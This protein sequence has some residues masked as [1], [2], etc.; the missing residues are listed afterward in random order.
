M[1]VAAG[2]DGRTAASSW[3]PVT[4]ALEPA[5]PVAATLTVGVGGN[6][7]PV[8]ETVRVEVAAGSRKV[9][10]FVVPNGDVRVTI[11]ESDAEPLTVRPPNAGS[12]A[13]FLVGLLGA[14]A[15]GLPPLRS[16]LIG[17]SG[18]WVFV[19][20]A[21]LEQ[22]SFALEPL[23]TLVADV[24]ALQE[25]TPRGRA[26]LAAGVAAG[27]DLVIVG[28]VV[29]PKALGLPWTVPDDA[30]RLDGADLGGADVPVGTVAWAFPAGY[31]RI[32]TTPVRPG[33][34][35]LGR[36]GELWSQL[37]QPNPRHGDDQTDYR[38][39]Q[40]PHQFTRLLA[41][42]GGN[43]PALPWLG[44]FVAA[45]VIVVGPV[46]GVLLSRMRR[47]ELAWAT[48]PMVTVIFTL[49]AFLGATSGRPPTGAAARLAFWNDGA[50]AEIVAAGVRAATPGT[51]VLQ[52]D[53]ADWTARPL[54][55]NG[56]QGIVSRGTDT[57][58]TLDLTALQ[59]GGVAAWRALDTAAPMDVE[60]TAMPEGVEVVIRNTS[61]RPLEEVAVRVATASRTIALLAPGAVETVTLGGNRLPVASAYRDPFEGL[62]LDQNGVV[63]APLSL[64]A[65]LNTEVADGRPG[66]A[67]VSAVDRTGPGVAVRSGAEEVTDHGSVVA[68]GARI[69][70]GEGL[71]PYTIERASFSTANGGYRP[72]PAAIEGAGEAFLRYRLPPGADP[73][74]LT[75]D[76]ER[77]E[78]SGGRPELT[79]WDRIDRQWVP[80]GAA[81]SDVDPDRLVSPL[82]EVWVRASGELFPF[83]FSGRT[84]A[85]GGS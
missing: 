44:A 65:V 24:A 18:A 64:R 1:T 81:L 75:N 23:G 73:T 69:A 14:S 79:V 28:E 40:V 58:A 10:R 39:A 13:E 5:R 9:Y 32:V 54:I 57:T 16:E 19:D 12:S 22:S 61:G 26:N 38:V 6:W 70:Q 49:G 37:T 53:G 42:P 60:A 17:R 30:W 41:E 56:K 29:D 84:I 4:V 63:G 46:N 11:A 35:G 59:L 66:L 47:R 51:R 34:P 3:Q 71:S 85:G 77:G 7:G 52:L 78:Q 76:L 74:L 21:W 50:G 43:A 33:D 55:D 82:G 80:A 83:E 72:G 27:T 45:Y 15:S 25:L 31:G 36:S 62:P 67:W 8:G 48:V 2:Y 20:H 68:V